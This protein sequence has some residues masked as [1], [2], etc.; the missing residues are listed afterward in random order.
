MKAHHSQPIWIKYN[1][2]IC[3]QGIT[4]T[5]GSFYISTAPCFIY[6]ESLLDNIDG[7]DMDCIKIP[8]I[9]PNLPIE[10]TKKINTIK[11]FQTYDKLP[12]DGKYAYL[13]LLNGSPTIASRSKHIFNHYIAGLFVRMFIDPETTNEDRIG[14]VKSLMEIQKLTSKFDRQICDFISLSIQKYLTSENLSFIPQS[15]INTSKIVLNN[16]INNSINNFSNFNINELARL[17]LETFECDLMFQDSFAQELNQNLKQI[18]QTAHVTKNKNKNKNDSYYSFDAILLLKPSRH[19]NFKVLTTSWSNEAIIFIKELKVF[20]DKFYKENFKDLNEYLQLKNFNNGDF[21]GA[22][23]F[24]PYSKQTTNNPVYFFINSFEKLFSK[25]EYFFIK[26]NILFNNLLGFNAHISEIFR[27]EYG[28]LILK[29]L[30]ELGILIYPNRIEHL[31]TLDKDFVLSKAP[32][33]GYLEIESNTLKNIIT[34]IKTVIFIIQEDGIYDGDTEK[35]IGFIRSYT[36]NDYQL[37]YCIS[38]FW[39][40]HKTTQ[41]LKPHLE[42]EL[43]ILPTQFRKEVLDNIKSFAL[44]NNELNY[45]RIDQIER[46][47]LCMG[48]NWKNFKKELECS[49]QIKSNYY[50]IPKKKKLFS[51]NNKTTKEREKTII[52]L[53]LERITFFEEQTKESQQIL[54]EIFNNKDEDTTT[55]T[56]KNDSSISEI[57]SIIMSK[58]TWERVELEKLSSK[59]NFIL[60]SMLE[61]INDYSYEKINEIVIDDDNDKIYVNTEYK[62]QLL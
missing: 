21:L 62:D 2:R 52:T 39:H 57:L 37:K 44:T 19:I 42:K 20:Y 15:F 8:S 40:S 47:L 14:I 55:S 11:T 17:T 35:L 53:D 12:N 16:Y 49:I 48:E 50:S 18:Y 25:E 36:T 3:I 38:I 45:E 6:K 1:E 59:H 34:Y 54:S 58:R 46:V 41:Y 7:F 51:N 43:S 32:L 28:N 23:L 29:R 26:P 9:N 61:Q 27:R 31:T 24:L 22:K 33:E 56:I 4:T 30:C 60:N 10:V 5:I 13:L